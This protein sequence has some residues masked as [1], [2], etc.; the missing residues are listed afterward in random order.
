MT[1]TTTEK[2]VKKKL[3]YSTRFGELLN[4]ISEKSP[5]VKK[6]INSEVPET[7]NFNYIDITDNNDVLTFIRNNRVEQIK[8]EKT[9]YI[10]LSAKGFQKKPSIFRKLKFKT[11]E[12]GN[13]L[14]GTPEDRK[15]RQK[16][17]DEGVE[18]KDLKKLVPAKGLQGKVG[19]Y[20]PHPDFEA[21]PNTILCK[22]ID[23]K[24]N[25]YLVSK[26]NLKEQFS[27]QE[28]YKGSGRVEVKVGKFFQSL[29]LELKIDVKDKEIEDLVNNFKT[30]MDIL[31]DQLKLFRIIEGKDIKEI[32]YQRNNYAK[33]AGT[34][35][36]S[37][38][39]NGDDNGTRSCDLYV[40]NPESVRLI[41]LK[42]IK[43]ENKI[44]GRALLWKSDEGEYYMD[45][46][47]TQEP[48]LEG[49][50]RELAKKAGYLSHFDWQKREYNDKKF[51]I[52]LKNKYNG[53]P[54]LDSMDYVNGD[55]LHLK[56]KRV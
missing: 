54:F 9:I 12:K 34:L 32:G 49:L 1:K 30:T 15:L 37:C 41:V 28:F 8:E 23:E 29:F 50:F 25:E 44:R 43:D 40:K 51:N 5:I 36:Q 13:F 42:D 35:S 39:T 52:T 20:C 47:Y 31:K 3:T 16:Q 27:E 4:T 10:N 55:V 53:N 17:I 19:G 45:R 14:I 46:V 56:L 33:N 22:F 21:H 11:D 7:F 48:A 26:A 38:M 6:L 2:I 24:G 18:E